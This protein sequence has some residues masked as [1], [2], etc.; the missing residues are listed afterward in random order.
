MRYLITFSLFIILFIGCKKEDNNPVT[1]APDT[2]TV[3]IVTPVNNQNILDSITIQI[4]AFDPKG[5]TKVELFI[6][7]IKVTEFAIKPYI[8][9]WDVKNLIDSSKYSIYAKAYN[10]DDKV[11]GSEV[12]EVL[13]NKLSPSNL[14]ILLL[15]KDTVQLKWKDNSIIEESYVIQVSTDSVNF[16]TIVELPANTTEA[17][18]NHSFSFGVEYYFRVGAKK[19]NNVLYSSVLSGGAKPDL[20]ILL[21]PENNAT[22][23]SKNVTFTWSASAGAESYLLQVSTNR[24]FTSYLYNQN[25]GNTSQPISGLDFFKKYYWRV[26]AN[27]S[28]GY[29][30]WTTI[31]SFT[32]TNGSCVG[33]PTVTYSGKTYNTIQI[34]SQCWL[35]ENLNVGTMMNGGS[36]QTNNSTI[37]KYCYSETNC[38][39][40]GGL[41]QWNEAMGYVTTPGAQGICPPG[42]HIPTFAEFQALSSI[43]GGNSNALKAVGQ[44]SGDGAGTNTSGFSA[45]LAGYRMDTGG[46][47]SFRDAYFWS[48]SE[49]NTANAISLYLLNSDSDISL[50]NFKKSHGFSV[51]CIQD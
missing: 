17:S 6:Q 43:V 28:S 41:Y 30:N 21:S 3:K 32:T 39:T 48:S 42:W 12:L 51:R 26:R 22:D 24:N 14:E 33:T 47:G 37:E 19:S 45:L 16:N 5:V 49:S 1:P 10:S 34:G 50:F 35:K 8:Y 7:N 15:T 44:G 46:F 11:T 36:N 29:S 20:P 31:L 27:N 2:P 25:V 13:I 40:Y 4:E 9:F 38:N 18:I 23:V